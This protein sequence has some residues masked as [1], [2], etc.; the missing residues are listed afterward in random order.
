M[1]DRSDAAVA[2][3]AQRADSPPGLG[4]DK[5]D[6]LALL[7]VLWKYKYLIV[8]TTVLC[9][10]VA[11]VLALVATPVFRAEV[12]ITEVTNQ[13]MGGGSSLVNQLGGLA[14]IV[15]VN[16]GS[17]SGTSRE[18]QGLLKSRYLAEEFVKR[19]ELR[20]QIYRGAKQTPSLWF[21]VRQFRD[22]LLSVRDDKRSGLTIVSVSWTDPTV[23][24]RWAN[25]Y[26]ALANEMLRA[27]AI[28]ESKASIEYLNGQIA[29]TNVVDLQRV[30]YNLIENETKTLMLANVKAEYAFTVVDPAVAPEVRSSP[31]RTLMVL[32]GLTFGFLVGAVVAFSINTLRSQRA[33]ATHV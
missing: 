4:P 18:A 31:R 7:R 10:A 24:A 14:S 1:N 6:F 16:L 12:S 8:L 27:R 33:G 26:V 11:V 2:P 32:L 22:G 28:S 3:A 5:V 17:G 25:E 21:T 15:G 19:Y 23:A 29:H 20:P 30:M 13:G 9:G